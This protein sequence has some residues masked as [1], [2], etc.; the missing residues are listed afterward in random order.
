MRCYDLSEKEGT[1]ATECHGDEFGQ[2]AEERSLNGT[3]ESELGL[4]VHV[5]IERA[6]WRLQSIWSISVEH[7]K[8]GDVI[9]NGSY[10]RNAGRV[11]VQLRKIAPAHASN[12]V[13]GPN[14][15]TYR[16]GTPKV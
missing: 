16:T 7:S 14:M 6:R 3:H 4:Q 12:L 5:H 10:C 8:F 13:V 9:Y 2:R 1:T 11:N 15:T